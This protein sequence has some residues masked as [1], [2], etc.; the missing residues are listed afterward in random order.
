MT[1]RAYQ[2]ERLYPWTCHKCAAE[3]LMQVEA[4]PCPNCGEPRKLVPLDECPMIIDGVHQGEAYQKCPA[5]GYMS[6][7]CGHLTAR[8]KPWC[9]DCHGRGACGLRWIHEDPKQAA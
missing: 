2:R 7:A 3:V 1:L 8:H 4:G 5:C 6:C 9:L